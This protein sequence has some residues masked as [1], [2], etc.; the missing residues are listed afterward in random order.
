FNKIFIW[1]KTNKLATFLVIIVLYLISKNTSPPTFLGSRM[2]YDSAGISGESFNLSAP[3]GITSKSSSYIREP[4]YE[5]APTPDIE[6][7][8]VIKNSN[9]SMQ[10]EDVRETINAISIKVRLLKGYVVNTFISTPEFGEDG[11]I[12]VRVPTDTLDATLEYFRGLAIKVVSENISGTDITDQY[13]D[14]QARLSRLEQTKATFEAMIDKAVKIEE[15]LNIQR[16]IFSIQSQI[17]NYK[18]QLKY[19]EEASKTA[20]I[21]IDV[22]T[23]ELGLPYE[24]IDEWSPKTVFKQAYR[25]FLSDLIKIGNKAIWIVV[26]APFWLIPVV[27]VLI[28]KAY[29]KRKQ[30]L[31]KTQ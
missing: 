20:L 30:N 14:I 3:S 23:S 27:A 12:E 7:R 22:S 5:A 26:Y 15:I 29:K 10:V 4:V 11:T 9:L 25:S 21:R 28:I 19:M 31:N 2:Q 18:G 13:V 6:N 17:D 16:E 8:M 1:V 24:P